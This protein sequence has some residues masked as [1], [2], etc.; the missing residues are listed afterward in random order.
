MKRV[1]M[2]LVIPVFSMVLAVTAMAYPIPIP[3]NLAI[4]FRDW[5]GANG[6]ANYTVGNVTATALPTNAKLYQ[7]NIDGLG[8]QGGENDEI[9]YINVFEQIRVDIAGG[10]ML[11]SGVWLTDLFAKQSTTSPSENYTG[12]AYTG[13]PGRVVINGA[14]IIDF[15]GIENNIGVNTYPNNGELFV[16]FG[17][18]PIVVT[19]ALFSIR[20]DAVTG[21]YAGI[22]YS[23]AGFESA[24]V[25]IPAAAWLLG[26]GLIG[27]VAVR[28]RM[29]K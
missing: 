5:G 12:S 1:L 7:D 18:T 17:A 8:V 11:L 29:K 26:S 13:E 15:V 24:P 22:E 23:V 16:S 6:Q 28:R 14:T 4:D 21:S 9:D 10:G 25:P 27:L 3:D 2:V 19:S 20:P